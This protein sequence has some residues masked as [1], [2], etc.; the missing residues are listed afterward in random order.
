MGRIEDGLG[1]GRQ[2]K[3]DSQRRLS[4]QAVSEAESEHSTEA[5]TSYNLNTGLISITA[6][7]TLMYY[8]YKCKYS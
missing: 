4:V 1:S 5:G 7:A 8:K 2:A 6:D 3:V